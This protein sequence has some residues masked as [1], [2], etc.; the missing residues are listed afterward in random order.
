MVRSLSLKHIFGSQTII[1]IA[2]VVVT[3]QIVDRSA[4]ETWV[5]IA[6]E[7]N[8][9]YYLILYAMITVAS[10]AIQI[11][12]LLTSA[13]IAFSNKSASA[14]SG[15]VIKYL[16]TVSHISLIA[17]I[18]YLLGEQL[19]TYRYH[20]SL[21]QMI[22]GLSFSISATIISSLAVM[23]LRSYSSRRNKM[24]GIYAIAMI[25]LI[26][27]LI[28]ACIY[29]EISLYNKP[30][31]VTSDRNPWIAYFY[32]SLQSKTLSIYEVS[33]AISFISVWFASIL[34]TKQ[35]YKE[36]WKRR[37]WTILSVPLIYFLL[38]YSPLLFTQTGTLSYLLMGSGPAFIYFYNFLL[39]TVSLGT[40]IL[41][42]ISFFLVSRSLSYHHLKYNL[43]ICGA[44]IMIIFST[45]IS[46]VLTLAPFPAWAIVS[47]SFILPASFL[48][49]VGIDSA[50]YYIVSDSSVRMFLFKNRN[51]FQLFQ[52][53]G[54]TETFSVIERRVRTISKA[55][56]DNLE[57]E[58][59]FK[60][61]PES[62]D[63]KEYVRQVIHEM[64]ETYRKL[65]ER[66]SSDFKDESSK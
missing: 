32:T 26:I 40:G 20:I 47:L 43:V 58:T 55:I 49:L 22:A 24:V 12:L 11:F 23:L 42:G 63:I 61:A 15:T 10:I 6:S 54:S 64:K 46:T 28:T 16:Y 66:K 30:Q 29:V 65:D 13:R 56:S 36:M 14:R 19:M 37:Y 27:Q 50:T 25:A 1:I 9:F 38:Q 62:E 53:L 60:P 21:S 4:G 33:K 39:N 51:Q 52:S 31:Y 41:F 59:L 2:F 34:L 48:I 18:A 57:T 44:G 7:S 17:F 5:T 8:S 3:I 35:F 45:S